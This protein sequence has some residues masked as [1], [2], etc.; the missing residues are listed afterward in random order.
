MKESE[1]LLFS[2]TTPLGFKVSVTKTY[3]EYIKT[4]KHPHIKGMESEVT[5]TLKNP[6]F[7]RQSRVDKNVYLFYRE[8]E[9]NN[10][11]Y[12]MCV[13]TNKNKGSIIT[14]YITDRI[15]EGVQIW[16]K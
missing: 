8:I 3:W 11:N 2:E 7:I 15:K 9:Y 13:V 16:K 14:A 12:H 6:D 4:I 1:E 10:K 5:I